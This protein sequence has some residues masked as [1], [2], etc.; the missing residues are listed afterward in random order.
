MRAFYQD[1]LKKTVEKLAHIKSV[2]EKLGDDDTPSISIEV[3]GSLESAISSVGSGSAAPTGKRRGRKPGPKPGAKKAKTSSGGAKPGRK[4]T[5]EPLIYETLNKFKRP[6]TYDDLTEE[7]MQLGG[8]PEEKRDNTKQALQSVIFR[9]RKNG[10]DLHT[11]NLG[12][13]EKHIVLED[14]LNN[15]GALKSEFNL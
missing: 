13:R 6:L 11:L 8:I 3:T 7:V 14:W 5:W 1:E 12:G 9:V 15:S 2:L 10:G 4:S